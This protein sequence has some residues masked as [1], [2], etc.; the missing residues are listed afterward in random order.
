MF[1]TECI[2]VVHTEIREL[3][4]EIIRDDGAVRTESDPEGIHDAVAAEPIAA[5]HVT[6]E[7]HE[8]GSLF[9]S[10]DLRDFL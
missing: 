7:A 8:A 4:A 9:L 2:A 3:H 1:F 6:L 10:A 5:L